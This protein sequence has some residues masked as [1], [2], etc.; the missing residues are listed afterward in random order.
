[1]SELP[2]WQSS[3]IEEI[4]SACPRAADAS[5]GDIRELLDT[6]GKRGLRK[7]VAFARKNAGQAGQD[8]AEIAARRRKAHTASILDE[9]RKGPPCEHGVPGG[10]LPHPETGEPAF[11]AKCRFMARATLGVDGSVDSGDTSVS[12]DDLPADQEQP[13]AGDSG[14]SGV[15]PWQLWSAAEL[16]GQSFPP[17]R[18]AVE[19]LIPEGVMVLA[20]APK[21]GKSWLALNLAVDVATGSKALGAV[22]TV[23]GDVLYLALED[24]PRRLQRRLR[25]VLGD[26]PAP[27]RLGLSVQCPPTPAHAL[28]LIRGWLTA[29]PG[30]RLVIIDV[31]ERIRGPRLQDETHYSAEY[32]VMSMV[33]KLADEYG[34]SVVLIHHVR[35]MSSDDFL[36]EISGTTGLSGAAD[37]I[38][39]LK[40]ARGE[41]DGTLSITGRDVEESEYALKFHADRGAWEL[42]G[43]AADYA[44]S[45]ET[46]RQIMNCLRAGNDGAKPIDVAKKTGLN[47]DLVKKTMLRMAEAGQLEKGTAGRYFLPKTVPAVPEA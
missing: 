35:K 10:N 37:T 32:R 23:Q 30:A 27:D 47:H 9:L 45:T 31:F 8:L 15:S 6:Y 28:T 44:A 33:K 21:V 29:H 24:T 5:D 2:L 19:G 3:D 13:A 20:G 41:H 4:R 43:P 40:R 11:C 36:N 34:I 14:D 17:P 18:F 38:I 39:V 12:P 16:L 25:Q 46:R 42:L 7:P 1:M 22:G 26:G